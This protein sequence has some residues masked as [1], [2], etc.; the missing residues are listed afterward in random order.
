MFSIPQR[1]PPKPLPIILSVSS[2]A[3]YTVSLANVFLDEWLNVITSSKQNVPVLWLG[4]QAASYDL[5][6]DRILAEGNDA[7]WRYSLEMEN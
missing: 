5:P 2:A 3:T 4:P 7:R 1:Y 6:E